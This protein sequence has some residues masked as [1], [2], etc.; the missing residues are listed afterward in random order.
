[1]YR[2]PRRYQSALQVYP[3]RV[4]AFVRATHCCC[5]TI[6]TRSTPSSPG[7]STIHLRGSSTLAVINTAASLSI[8]RGHTGAILVC[9]LEWH[10]L[11]STDI[12]GI[13]REE[14]AFV[15]WSK[16]SCDTIASQYIDLERRLELA[17]IFGKEHLTSESSILDAGPSK[18]ETWVSSSLIYRLSTRC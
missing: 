13:Q 1:M 3:Y 18:F 8:A 6:L 15:F 11:T 5:D 14:N 4:R 9:L 16:Q 10:C 12:V 2:L 7:V 17:A